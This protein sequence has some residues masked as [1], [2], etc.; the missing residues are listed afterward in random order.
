MTPIDVLFLGAD[1]TDGTFAIDEEFRLVEGELGSGG[2]GGFTMKSDL[3]VQPQELQRLLNQYAPKLLHF[4]GHVT[5]AGE[6]MLVDQAG[7]GHMVSSNL[8]ARIL[9]TAT[10]R[11]PCVVLNACNGEVLGPALRDVAEVIVAMRGMVTVRAAQTFSIRFYEALAGG[12]SVQRAFEQGLL[13]VELAGFRPELEARLIE[14][15]PG[16]A[17]T[18]VLTDRERIEA[19]RGAP[20]SAAAEPSPSTAAPAAAAEPSP[21]GPVQPTATVPSPR[22]PIP[23]AAAPPSRDNIFISYSH[24]DAD[25]MERLSIMLR[26]LE[27]SIGIDVWDDRR[28][29]A[30]AS[31]RD[32]I[33]AAL[34]RAKVAV[35]LVS[36]DFLASEFIHQ[37]ELPVIL[38]ARERGELDVLWCYLAPCLV[39][40]TALAEIQAAHTPMTPLVS[41]SAGEQDQAFLQI[42]TRA[43]KILRT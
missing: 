21:R 10:R 14:H 2:H 29:G 9:S 24:R 27:R 35:L 8:F 11:I 12:R 23:P 16:R 38:A 30:S 13:E 22:G 6:L 43:S 39:D 32:E 37:K 34:A 26:P 18:L 4:S 7:K 19:P 41:M 1:P 40:E 25:W 17:G 3:D 31:W 36:P 33:E 28:I 5:E 42:A 20:I 15:E